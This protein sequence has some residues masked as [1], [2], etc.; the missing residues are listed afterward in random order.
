MMNIQSEL[1]NIACGGSNKIYILM[2][3]IVVHALDDL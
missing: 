2:N 3:E 1:R